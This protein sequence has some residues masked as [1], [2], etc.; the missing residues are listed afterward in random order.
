MYD[1]LFGQ[2]LVI[3]VVLSALKS[4]AKNEHRRKPLVMSFHGPTGTGKSYVATIILKHIFKNGLQSNFARRYN[5][6]LHF[7]L[8]RNVELYQVRID[9]T[10]CSPY[11]RLY[12]L[13]YKS[14]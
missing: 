14:P 5:A 2:P 7:P 9:E 4:H 11:D 3:D 13:L 1:K 10:I 6:K 12:R 8:Q